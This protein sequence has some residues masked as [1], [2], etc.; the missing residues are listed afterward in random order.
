[1][2][3]QTEEFNTA[4]NCGR[5]NGAERRHFHYTFYI[6]ERRNGSE[7]RSGKDR[8]KTIRTSASML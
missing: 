3:Q 5:R 4:D 2:N 6:P 8:R 1:M 7:R